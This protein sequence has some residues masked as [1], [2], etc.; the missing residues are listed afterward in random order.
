MARRERRVLRDLSIDIPN[1]KEEGIWLAAE[2]DNLQRIHFVFPG[3]VDTPQHGGLFH[4]MI[5]VNDNYPHSPN[6][7]YMFTPTG[8]L[9]VS[10]YPPNPN[11][12]GICMTMS[13]YHPEEWSPLWTFRTMILGLISHMNDSK[14]E[15][16]GLLHGKN[17]KSYT[18]KSIE[19][20]K[21]DEIVK[22]L[23]PELIQSLNDGTWSAP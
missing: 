13:S 17:Q 2:K 16:K 15:G 23:F 18:A 1:L 20:I 6:S 12:R 10:E 9:Q 5:L 22:S 3:P 8:R 4:G 21:N 11:N 7:I 19:A 14:A